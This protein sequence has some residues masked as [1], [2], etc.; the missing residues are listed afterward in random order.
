MTNLGFELLQLIQKL[1]GVTANDALRSLQ[2]W[3]DR[4]S[5]VW[6]RYDCL[7]PFFL[8]GGDKRSIIE[9]IKRLIDS[10]SGVRIA[11]IH[12][13]KGLE[14]PNIYF[15]QP[16]LVGDDGQEQNLYYVAVTRSLRNLYLHSKEST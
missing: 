2:K 3:R 13:A 7:E 11:T 9:S 10:Q 5:A 12:K 16:E 6:E 1:D 4:R 8:E 15:E 14:S